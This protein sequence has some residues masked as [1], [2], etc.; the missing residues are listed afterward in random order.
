MLPVVDKEGKMT[1][2]ITFSEIYDA[3]NKSRCSVVS[4]EA[5]GE[6]NQ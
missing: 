4:P 6:Q 1:G 2:Q 5:S 3:L